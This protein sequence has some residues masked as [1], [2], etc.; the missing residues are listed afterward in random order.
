M[1]FLSNSSYPSMINA[2]LETPSKAAMLDQLGHDTEAVVGI[3]LASL[4]SFVGNGD[5]QI[6]EFYDEIVDNNSALWEANLA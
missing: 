6:R 2:L 4:K 5:V 1:F 3:N